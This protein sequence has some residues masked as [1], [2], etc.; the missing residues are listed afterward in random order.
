MTCDNLRGIVNLD[1][2]VVVKK[3]STKEDPTVVSLRQVLLFKFKLSD[4]T[5]LV[6]EVHQRGTMGLVDVIVPNIPEAEAMLLMMNRH[7]PAFCVHYLTEKG[8]DKKLVMELVREV[9]CPTL[10]G[11]IKECQWDSA[12]RT[13]TTAAQIEE[14]AR[15][16]EMEKA[17]WYQ[18]EFGKNM[19]EKVRKTKSYADAEAL[20]ALDGERS[21]KTLHARNDPKP[22]APKKRKGDDLVADSTLDSDLSASS[23]QNG[24]SD[25]DISM[26]SASIAKFDTP[27]GKVEVEQGTATRVRFTRRA[28]ASS[29]DGSA[30][31]P[32]AKGG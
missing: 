3:G 16:Q 29:V 20:Y 21:V 28:A 25:D 15:M 32:S 1:A 12:T 19:L 10:V 18:D 13:I 31:S 6:A 7:F 24:S 27:T 30:P 11:S 4:G 23:P 22:S 14:D 26:D 9:C 17:A 2:E 8:M 5:S